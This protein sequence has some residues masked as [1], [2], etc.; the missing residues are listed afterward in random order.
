MRSTFF[1]VI[2]FLSLALLSACNGPQGSSE[3]KP[4]ATFGPAVQTR[5]AEANRPRPTRTPTPESM[6]AAPTATPRPPAPTPLPTREP[7]LDP[8]DE[9]LLAALLT[10]DE[11]PDGWHGGDSYVDDPAAD[12]WSGDD[13]MLFAPGAD[14]YCGT[15]FDDPYLNQ[16][17]VYFD[18]HESR[19]MLIQVLSLY[20][21]AQA[22]D[23]LLSQMFTAM[24]RCPEFE[25]TVAGETTVTRITRLEYPELGDRS[26]AFLLTFTSA[27]FELDMV[28]AAF[29][30]DRVVSI[31]LHY[32]AIAD[33]GPAEGWGTE[34]ITIRALEKI[35][36][37][38]EA[39]DALE[40]PPANV[41]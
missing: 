27:D 21:N 7:E 3:P 4:T 11:M 32:G 28:L 8:A 39:I 16:T 31:V 26:A 41:V 24:E 23:L 25:E 19:W 35:D 22:A 5:L 40:R 15:D 37:L 18:E 30:I 34:E 33:T 38:R 36:A 13:D 6:A 12:D 1:A 14:D 10:L 17:L 29:R 2:T 20:A 9:V